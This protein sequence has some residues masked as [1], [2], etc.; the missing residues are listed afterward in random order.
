MTFDRAVAFNGTLAAALSLFNTYD[1][2]TQKTQK[3]AVP[4]AVSAGLGTDGDDFNFDFHRY[5]GDAVQG[6]TISVDFADFLAFRGAF[7]SKDGSVS[8][9]DYFD[10]DDDGNVDFNDFL[11]FRER[12]GIPF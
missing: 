12:F 2:A 4:F 7:G 5:F 3:V 10:F 1:P 9:L 6:T 11:A 8:Y